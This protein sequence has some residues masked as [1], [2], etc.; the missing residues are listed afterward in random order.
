MKALLLVAVL[1]I[2]TTCYAADG[3]ITQVEVKPDVASWKLDTVK[4]LVIP[5]ICEVTYRKV[6]GSGD[7]VGDEVTTTFSEGQFTALVSA[8]NSGNNIKT[9]IKNAVEQKL[10]L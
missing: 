3:D 7:P 8:I 10:G 9:T 1:L 5:K 2:S 4:F 6:D